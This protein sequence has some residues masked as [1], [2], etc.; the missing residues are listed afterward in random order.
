MIKLNRESIKLGRTNIG[1]KVSG[2]VIK[3]NRPNIKVNMK[4]FWPK[5]RGKPKRLKK[6]ALVMFYNRR[7]FGDFC[8]KKNRKG[9][10]NL[11]KIN[12]TNFVRDDNNK[13]CGVILENL[14]R[15]FLMIKKIHLVRRDYFLKTK[16]NFFNL[17]YLNLFKKYLFFSRLQKKK[18]RNIINY[19]NKKQ[20][21]Y[22]DKK[23]KNHRV[24]RMRKSEVKC[25]Q[26]ALSFVSRPGV[27]MSDGF[28]SKFDFLW[29]SLLYFDFFFAG[30][31]RLLSR[32]LF[33][34]LM[35]KKKIKA[36]R[37]LK[38][39]RKGKRRKKK[40]ALFFCQ[41]FWHENLS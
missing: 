10:Y 33:R 14:M 11:A 2:D 22:N 6:F 20:S 39:A 15:F 21:V 25:E 19:L 27:A 1:L 24:Y 30:K 13:W 26:I 16:L 17:K 5:V 37:V 35:R 12:L 7:T 32:L 4:N 34:L 38:R 41:V 8:L 3:I 29:S 23:Y 31:S 9:K 36:F 40:R 28:V 18:S